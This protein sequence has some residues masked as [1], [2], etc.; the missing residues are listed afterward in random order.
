[1]RTKR[2]ILNVL[3]VRHLTK[4]RREKIQI[5]YHKYNSNNFL[6]MFKFVIIILNILTSVIYSLNLHKLYISLLK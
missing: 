3:I 5:T 2:A 4:T 1:M 6:L